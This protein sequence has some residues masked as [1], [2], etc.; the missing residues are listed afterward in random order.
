MSDVDGFKFKAIASNIIHQTTNIK[1]KGVL[2]DGKSLYATPHFF[3]VGVATWA[4]RLEF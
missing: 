4:T 1:E 2:H 3:T